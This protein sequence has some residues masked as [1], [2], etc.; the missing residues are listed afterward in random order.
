MPRSDDEFDAD[1]YEV[2]DASVR[3]DNDPPTRGRSLRALERENELVFQRAEARN[4]GG[5]EH[6]SAPLGDRHTT[7]R[8]TGIRQRRRYKVTLGPAVSFTTNVCANGF[9]TEVMRVLPRGATVKGSLHVRGVEF[10]FAGRIAWVQPGDWHIN[11]RGRMGVH[12]TQIHPDLA[13][14]LDA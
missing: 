6:Q 12:F 8:R 10:A 9:C 1:E 4:T 7:Q 2:K 3:L 14:L 11:L 5:V 13:R